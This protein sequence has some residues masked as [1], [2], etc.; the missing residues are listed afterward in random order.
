[1]VSS[2]PGDDHGDLRP[3]DDTA[4]RPDAPNDAAET[5]ARS[6]IAA[7]RRKI[8]LLG[9]LSHQ[10]AGA[11]PRHSL[12]ER[13]ANACGELLGV[14]GVSITLQNT[15]PQRITLWSTDQ[16]AAR[17]EDLQDVTGEGPSQLAF[18][19]GRTINAPLRP[20][21]AWPE[22]TAAALALFGELL[23]QSYPIRPDGL[24]IGALTTYRRPAAEGETRPADEAQF[25]ADAIGAALLDDAPEGHHPPSVG[26]WASRAQVHQAAG[27]VTAQLRIPPSDSL[28]L[29]RAH[30]FAHGT[31]LQEIA[32]QVLAGRLDFGSG[33][34]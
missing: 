17:L 34:A 23:L 22:F 31:T 30:A 4:A 28:A 26:P 33:S 29:L 24:V 21:Q 14:D 13:L 19:S 25:L 20:G 9:R 16:I 18:T 7:A 8:M 1:L 10:I 12:P 5:G 15:T 2:F 11:D 3:P 27:M 32:A 6:D